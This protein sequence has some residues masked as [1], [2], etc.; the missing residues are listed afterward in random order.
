LLLRIVKF[1][2]I[3]QQPLSGQY[4]EYPPEEVIAGVQPISSALGVS[5]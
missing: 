4:D 3:K 5:L 1:I 2:Y